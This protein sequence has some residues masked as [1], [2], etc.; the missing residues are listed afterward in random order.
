MCFLGK[1]EEGFSSSYNKVNHLNGSNCAPQPSCLSVNSPVFAEGRTWWFSCS[2]FHAFP[3]R[4]PTCLSPSHLPVN[5][6]QPHG[7]A[8]WIPLQLRLSGLLCPFS[9]FAVE[10]FRLI[11]LC[12]L[13]SFF[14]VQHCFQPVLVCLGFCLDF[15][16][17]F[18]P[19][20]TWGGKKKQ[21]KKTKHKTFPVQSFHKRTKF[22][23]KVNWGDQSSSGCRQWGGSSALINETSLIQGEKIISTAIGHTWDMT[24]GSWTCQINNTPLILSSHATKPFSRSWVL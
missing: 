4:N 9:L 6:C 11:K 16:R 10:R 2:S 20:R 8:W 12:L 13:D 14:S 15:Q 18:W 7:C 1:K 19:T 21:P 17:L 5:L 22:N 23:C 3:T 24:P